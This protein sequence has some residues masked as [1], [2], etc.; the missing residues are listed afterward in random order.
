MASELRRVWEPAWE[1]VVVVST[2]LG[3]RLLRVIDRVIA[4]YSL[5]PNQPFFDPDDFSWVAPVEAE[6]KTIRRELDDVLSYQDALPNF[7]DISVDQLSLTDDDRWKTFFFYGYGFKSEPNCA[8]CPE[9][10]R[11]VERIP[12]MQTAMFSILSPR[13][14]IPPHN[15]PYKGVLRYHLGLLVPEPEDQLGISVGGQVAEWREGE[16]LV[17]DDTFEHFVWNDT[18]GTRV[19]L[20]LD[21]VRE[22]RGPMRAFN[23]FMIKAIGFSPF[24][25]DARRRHEAWERRFERLQK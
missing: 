5:I 19:V 25:Q 16:S 22:L 8:R 1:R 6:W 15:G 10:A 11:I 20:F 14:H 13:K 3:D 24:I 23:S 21:V 18:D 2:R 7:Q 4:K 12:G 9:T 17:F